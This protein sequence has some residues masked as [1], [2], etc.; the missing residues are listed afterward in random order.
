[1][2]ARK[3]ACGYKKEKIIIGIN[4]HISCGVGILQDQFSQKATF[5]SR[6]CKRWYKDYFAHLPAKELTTYTI[7]N[8]S[9]NKGNV[10]SPK[11]KEFTCQFFDAKNF[12]AEMEKFSHLCNGTLCSTDYYHMMKPYHMKSLLI[13]MKKFLVF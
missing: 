1:M 7:E 8:D 2:E 5:D 13:G 6:Y 4:G 9:I 3:I 10:M 11:A 12:N